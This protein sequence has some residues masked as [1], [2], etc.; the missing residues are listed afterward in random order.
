MLGGDTVTALIKAKK[1]PSSPM[2]IATAP[3]YDPVLDKRISSQVAA[4][5]LERVAGKRTLAALGRKVPVFGGG[6]GLVSD[7]LATFQVG[8]YAA[9]ELKARTPPRLETAR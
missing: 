1:L 3:A 8:R 7:G 5:L 9:K 6:I 4:E 2:A